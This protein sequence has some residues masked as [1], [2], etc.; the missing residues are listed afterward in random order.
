M[1]TPFIGENRDTAR[2]IS[3]WRHRELLR[4]LVVRNFKLK[5]K[6]SVLGFLWTFL[7][8]LF[9]VAVL[10]IVFTYVVR[11]P[12]PNYWAFLLSGYFVWSFIQQSVSLGTYIFVEHANLI[13]SIAFPK[14]ALIIAAVLTRLLE[15]MAELF[16]VLIVLAVVHHQGVPASFCLVPL[17]ILLQLLLAVGL[18]MPIA[19]FSV[20][21][22]DV[23]HVLPVAFTAIFYISP[24]FYPVGLVPENLHSIYLSN[25]VAALLTLY[26]AVLYEGT[27]P[28]AALLGATVFVTA[29]I[30]VVGYVIFN[31]FKDVFAEI[32]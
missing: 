20:F 28:S 23:Q 13:R 31:R 18:V 15:Y 9:M 24:V 22:N 25:P 2:S 27:I 4:S 30:A 8:P 19:T 29:M 10:V 16:P 6:R 7:N 17:L 5:Y 32:V 3:I 26:H 21:Y 12:L 11:I 1:S 14:E